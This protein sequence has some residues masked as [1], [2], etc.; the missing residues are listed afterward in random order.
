MEAAS[1][2]MAGSRIRP[3]KSSRLRV[4]SLE[5]KFR[6]TPF[7]VAICSDTLVSAV[8]WVARVAPVRTTYW[9]GSLIFSVSPIL[10]PSLAKLSSYWR[11]M[12]PTKRSFWCSTASAL[13]VTMVGVRRVLATGRGPFAYGVGWGWVQSVRA[14]LSATP[15]CAGGRV[16]GPS[17]H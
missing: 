2:A 5:V 3:E 8:S 1:T 17:R 11:L 14:R 7:W 13:R 12:E 10:A 15:A 16:P 4:R 9:F 6:S